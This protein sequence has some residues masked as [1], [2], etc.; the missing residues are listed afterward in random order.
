MY[1]NQRLKFFAILVLAVSI[2][3]NNIFIGYKLAGISYDRIFQLLFFSCIFGRYLRDL[4]IS[5]I[6]SLSIFIFILSFLLIIKDLS[7]LIQRQEVEP[8]SFIR[9]LTRTFTYGIFT[10]LVFYIARYKVSLI[11]VILLVYFS[12]FLLAFFQNPLTPFTEF[13]QALRI[14]LFYSNMK[15]V[16]L[17]I[18]FN[19]LTD[20]NRDFMRVAG[21]YGQT[22]TL[23]YALV[24]CSIL[25]SYMYISFRRNI[26]LALHFFIL[27]VSVMTLTRSAVAAILLLTLYLMSASRQMLLIG[28]AVLLCFAIYNVETIVSLEMFDRVISVDASSKGKIYLILTGAVALLLFPIGVT[29]ENYMSVKKWMYDI[30]ENQDILVYPSHNG[31]INLGFEYT[32]LVYI[33]FVFLVIK[34]FKAA[35]VLP[36]DKARFWILAW[37]AFFLHQSFHNNG[38]FYVEFNIL[39]VLGVFFY[40]IWRHQMLHYSHLEGSEFNVK[41]KF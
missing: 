36:K 4:N 1:L 25:T 14:E 28:L 35:R 17:D 22:I 11:N 2:G 5:L 30:F 12:A 39:I 8:I 3:L 33:P 38:I 21:P 13:S 24:A 6:R 27:V 32:S 31:L 16:D 40:D 34:F 26:F 37:L 9:E 41:V 19:F 15:D 29:D 10:Y 7:L 20:E 23:S 18:Y